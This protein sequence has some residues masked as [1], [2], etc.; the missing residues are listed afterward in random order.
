M[1]VSTKAGAILA[2]ASQIAEEDLT[3]YGNGSVNRALDILADVLAGEDVDVP[4]TNAGAILALADYIGGGG[5]PVPRA[6]G[7]IF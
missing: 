2:V 5:A 7:V 3:P 1:N 6:A 4:K